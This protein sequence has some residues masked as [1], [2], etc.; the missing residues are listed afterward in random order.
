MIGCANKSAYETFEQWMK[1]WISKISF[2]IDFGIVKYDIRWTSDEYTSEETPLLL[3]WV[4]S[5]TILINKISLEQQ[6]L[7]VWKNPH[8]SRADIRKK[9]PIT[10]KRQNNKITSNLMSNQFV[11]FYHNNCWWGFKPDKSLSSTIAFKTSICS[12][13]P[14]SIQ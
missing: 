10:L 9:Y 4:V 13:E 3:S 8:T 2:F 11:F 1:M 14:S 7:Q 12:I 6:H 5:A